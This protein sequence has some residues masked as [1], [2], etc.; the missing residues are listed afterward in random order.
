MW[1]LDKKQHAG[2][3][4]ASSHHERVQSLLA[5][6]ADRFARDFTAVAPPLGS[7]EEMAQVGE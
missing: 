4:V 7:A 5:A 1:R 6:Y 3:I 2:L